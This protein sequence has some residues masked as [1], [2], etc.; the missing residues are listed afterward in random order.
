M[1]VNDQL[2][3]INYTTA[4]PDGAIRS[5]EIM[6]PADGTQVTEFVQVNGT[7]SIAPFENNL[8][9]FIYDEAGN[10]LGV[11][12]VTWSLRLILARPAPSAS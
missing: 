3:V 2:Q 4:T 12:P 6:S 1:L 11:G 9:Y 8:S 7:V 5:I 10:Q